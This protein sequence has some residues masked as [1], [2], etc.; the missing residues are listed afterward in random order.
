VGRKTEHFL[1][2][3]FQSSPDRTSKSSIVKMMMLQ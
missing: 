1:L 3:G 2:E